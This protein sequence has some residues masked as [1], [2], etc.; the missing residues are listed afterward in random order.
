MTKQTPVPARAMTTPAIAG[1]DHARSVE[2]AG[3]QCHRV[4]ERARSDHLVGERLPS[5]RVEGEGDPAERREDIDDRE[6]RGSGQRDHGE[7]NG[8][9]QRCS[10]RRHDE[11]S[12]VHA[13][14][15][16]TG[17]EAEDGERNEAAERE[18]PI[19]RADPESSS[20]SHASAMFCIHEPASETSC[21]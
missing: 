13:V 7:R 15:D 9:D 12:R 8:D 20:T 5:G 18:A 2:E 14:G 19:A 4:R 11:L 21:P 10:L 1:S 17:S 16:D 3:V 6:R